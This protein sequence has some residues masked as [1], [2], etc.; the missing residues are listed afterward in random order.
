MT[1]NIDP[2]VP[3]V[4]VETPVQE[5]APVH[6]TRTYTES[7]QQ[8]IDG[9]WVPKDQW[10]GDPDSWRPAKEFNDR[11]EFF[12]RIDRLEHKNKELNQALTFLTEQHKRTYINGFNDAIAK[13]RSQRDKALEEGDNL[14]AQRINDKIEDVKDRA[15]E[16]QAVVVQTQQRAPEPT[17]VYTSWASKNPWYTQDK[18]LTK[19]AEAVGATFKEENPSSAEAE[20]L[21]YVETEV[22]REFPHKFGPKGPPSPEGTGR[23][24]GPK[25]GSSTG[26]YSAIETNLTSEQRSIMNTMMK[27]AGLTKEEYLQMYSG[28]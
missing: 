20:M 9:G 12:K 11:G 23:G 7:E 16:A 3:D 22:K 26:K 19:Y 13:L 10:K 28:Q 17:P 24:T 2:V 5:L 1:D 18:V 27:S 8:A 15:K 6:E 4:P 14:S 21:K 25:S